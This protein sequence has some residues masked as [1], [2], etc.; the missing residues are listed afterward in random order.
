[1]CSSTFCLFTWIRTYIL[2]IFIF[3]PTVLLVNL[4]ALFFF[5]YLWHSCNNNY[6]S[7]QAERIYFVFFWIYID[8]CI[9]YPWT[10]WADSDVERNTLV[11]LTK[12][13]NSN[14]TQS[15]CLTVSGTVASTPEQWAGDTDSNP[16]P[17]KNWSV[18]ILILKLTVSL[19]ANFH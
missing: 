13:I 10:P 4:I 3:R 2:F 6:V 15:I 5:T 19:N 9:S 8:L 17:C 14:I 7:V 12:E 18:K 16:G 11:L 1:M